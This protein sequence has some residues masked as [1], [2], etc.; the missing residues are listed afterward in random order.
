MQTS[1][2]LEH[3]FFSIVIPAH[4]EE[5]GIGATLGAIRK[6]AYPRDSFETIVV[7]N[8]STDRTYELATAFESDSIRT[9]RSDK[10]VSR[11]KN[12]GLSHISEKS[13]WV[14]FLDADTHLEPG[15]LNDLNMYFLAHRERDFVVGTTSIRP[16]EHTRWSAPIW[17]TFHNVIHRFTHTSYSIQIMKASLRDRVRFDESINFSEDTKLIRDA[18][19]FG[20]FFFVPTTTVSTSIRRFEQNGWIWQ[21]FIWGGMFI[22]SKT[23]R[24]SDEYPV[25]R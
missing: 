18:R 9:L 4:N 7:E 17:F 24:K 6:L 23:K 10:G 16:I 25:I 2:E 20:K 1:R 15:F 5:S 11:A 19:R 3:Y 12:L 14:V 8:G 22:R 13:D 21:L